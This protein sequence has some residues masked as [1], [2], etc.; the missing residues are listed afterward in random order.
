MLEKASKIALMNAMI[1]F[2]IKEDYS[3][4]L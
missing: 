2:D 1:G 3:F 4:K